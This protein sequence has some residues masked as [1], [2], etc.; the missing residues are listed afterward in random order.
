MGSGQF[1]QVIPADHLPEYEGEE[2]QKGAEGGA[3]PGEGEEHR[4]QGAENGE[5][6][7]GEAGRHG[8]GA[9][10]HHP[11]LVLPVQGGEVEVHEKP[12][13]RHQKEEQQG[14]EE[15][16]KGLLPPGTQG[17]D[18]Q[19]H[20]Q[21]QEGQAQQQGKEE[22]APQEIPVG[23]GEAL[24][25]PEVLALQ[26]DRH[27]R[28]GHDAEGPGQ[29]E[30]D[31]GPD[32]K[33]EKGR[34]EHGLQVGEEEGHR[35]SHPHHR[36]HDGVGHVARRGEVPPQLPL[37]ESGGE[38]GA[39]LGGE[40]VVVLGR[41]H[42]QAAA[43][44]LE[45]G[46]D[47]QSHEDKKTQGGPQPEKGGEKVSPDQGGTHP[48]GGGID[49]AQKGEHRAREVPEGVQVQVLHRGEAEGEDHDAPRRQQGESGHPQALVL[50][51]GGEAGDDRPHQ[52]GQGEGDEG[53]TQGGQEGQ[54]VEQDPGPDQIGVDPKAGEKHGQRKGQV[55]QIHPGEPA[56]HDGALGDGEGAEGIQALL[57]EKGAPRFEDAEEKDH[58][59]SDH[60]EVGRDHIAQAQ[61]SETPGQAAHIEAEKGGHQGVEK[62]QSQSLPPGAFV[63]GVEKHVEAEEVPGFQNRQ[64]LNL[65]Q[66]G[67]P[68]P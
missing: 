48:E 66:H 58:H 31:E 5:G 67:S 68:P 16:P 7:A 24:G 44:G 15:E 29:H 6:H 22:L 3:D 37:A 2:Q 17:Q 42:R 36:A 19:D 39:L 26:G 41:V 52:G 65:S 43:D 55:L 33:G 56:H 57:G 34:G 14:E 4:R 28:G 27:R 54:G 9:L 11:C 63:V 53:G 32:V 21:E 38:G 62:G 46:G 47:R 30:G 60:H 50:H 59:G 1:F 23:E 20:R 18:G 61:G 40:P 12:Q 13:H 64:E 35:Q 45:P 10:L 51:P 8:G 25:D 49:L